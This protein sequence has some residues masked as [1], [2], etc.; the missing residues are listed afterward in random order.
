MQFVEVAVPTN[1]KIVVRGGQCIAL[2]L[3]R[4]ELKVPARFV[5]DDLARYRG[6]KVVC[7]ATITTD[8]NQSRERVPVVVLHPAKS[9]HAKPTHGTPFWDGKQIVIPQLPN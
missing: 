5:A 4:R 2:Q 9:K 1:A 8:R 7:Q 6:S 3:N